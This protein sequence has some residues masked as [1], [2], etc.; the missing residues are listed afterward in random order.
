MSKGNCLVCGDNESDIPMLEECL[1][2]A[3]SKVYTIWVTADQNLQE[4][5]KN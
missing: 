4:K 3:G 2:L 1:K 5:V